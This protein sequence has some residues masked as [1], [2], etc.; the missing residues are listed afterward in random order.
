MTGWMRETNADTEVLLEVETV[1][2]RLSRH[3]AQHD[4]AIFP[5]LFH[6]FI[7]AELK[8]S[9]GKVQEYLH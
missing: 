1:Q 9:C 4:R 5:F 2:T 7:I 8:I 6:R 3:V